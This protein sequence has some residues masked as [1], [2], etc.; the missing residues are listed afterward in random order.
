M[1]VGS[2]HWVRWVGV[3]WGRGECILGEIGE[4]EGSWLGFGRAPFDA[5]LL[6]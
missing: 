3:D 2:W 4:R 5:F 6:F 1:E